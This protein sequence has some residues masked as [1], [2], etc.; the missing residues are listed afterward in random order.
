MRLVE[1]LAV[2]GLAIGGD[3][4]GDIGARDVEQRLVF[5][6]RRAH[7]HQ[8]PRDR[9]VHLRDG[10]RGVVLV[11]IHRAGSVD[12]HSPGGLRHL[13]DLQVSQLI[14]RHGEKAGLTGRPRPRAC[15]P[16]FSTLRNPPGIT[17]AS[18]TELRGCT[19]LREIAACQCAIVPAWQTLLLIPVSKKQYGP[20]PRERR[21]AIGSIVE[22]LCGGRRARR[23]G[24][25]QHFVER[26]K[27]GRGRQP[28]HQENRR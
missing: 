21:R 16:P 6:D 23:T 13:R 17:R 19:Q 22:E 26:L 12:R 18:L 5:L 2:A 7:V 24:G 8:N 11:P 27:I 28:G 3:G 10:L 4:V 25:Q 14:R 9:P 15:F 20:A 1:L